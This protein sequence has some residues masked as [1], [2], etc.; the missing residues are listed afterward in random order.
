MSNVNEKSFSGTRDLLVIMYSKSNSPT[1]WASSIGELGNSHPVPCVSIRKDRRSHSVCFQP[2]VIPSK[3]RSGSR[4]PVPVV[5]ETVA[6]G[7]IITTPQKTGNKVTFHSPP[8]LKIGRL[9]KSDLEKL[10]LQQEEAISKLKEGN[11]SL[12]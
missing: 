6:A 8:P 10:A 9:K 4:E 2:K 5:L 11:V 7:G 1:C 3:T 12:I